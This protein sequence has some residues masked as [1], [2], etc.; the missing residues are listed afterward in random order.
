MLSTVN[1]LDNF[2]T[3]SVVH[4][5]NTRYKHQLHRPTVALSCMQNGVFYCSIKI[6][7]SLPSSILKLKQKKP[8]FKAAFRQYLTAHHL[9]SLHQFLPTSQITFPLLH[10]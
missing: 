4:R 1:N 7:N 10:Q 6:F 8:K 5:M 3:N 9:Y 2:Q